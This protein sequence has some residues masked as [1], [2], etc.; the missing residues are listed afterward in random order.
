M[1]NILLILF[2][3]LIPKQANSQVSEYNKTI[4]MDSTWNETT[5]KKHSFYRVI[6]DYYSEKDNYQIKDY[7]KSGHLLMAGSSKNKEEWY[8]EGEFISFYENGNKKSVSNYIKGRKT[9]SESE[10]F[11]NGNKKIDL[12]YTNYKLDGPMQQYYENG[13]L[14]SSS[15]FTDGLLDGKE[16]KW[17]ENGNKKIEGEYFRDKK[18]NTSK[19]VINQFW[20]DNGLQKVIDGNG[21][22]EEIN[23][24][25]YESGKV[26]T[27]LKNG[28]WKG[29]DNNVGYTFEEIY[30]DSKLISG[31]SIDINKIAHNY[32][33]KELKPCPKKGMNDF[34]THIAKTFK[35][36]T[37]PGLKGKVFVK[38]IIE[39]DGSI[40][41]IKVLRDTGYGSGDEAI[42]AV[43]SYKDWS[44]G[45]QRGI[46]IRAT[47]SL[48]ITINNSN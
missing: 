19:F 48:P 42:R 36:P 1:K 26:K 7:Y 47:Y 16:T 27:G 5:K 40:K 31:T 11:E 29:Y 21:D 34:Y 17:Y 38:F 28:V 15:N 13:Q 9:G 37:I 46:K 30:A 20:D 4:Y 44:P 23:K 43:S 14:K 41:D 24:N 45:E 32:T 2:F 18:N 8:K 10:W 35:G 12:N 33:L 3:I 6:E 22:Y 25:R 39:N